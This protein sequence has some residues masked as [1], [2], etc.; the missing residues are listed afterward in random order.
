MPEGVSPVD[1]GFAVIQFHGSQNPLFMSHFISL[2]EAAD[3][4]ARY[5]QY[6]EQILAT[7]YKNQNILPICET[8]DR[9]EI[10]TI[11]GKSGCDSLRIYYGMDTAYKVHAVIVGADTNG[12]DILPAGT[13]LTTTE[14][15]YIAERGFRCPDQ[16]PPDSDLNS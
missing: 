9:S 15:D 7:A 12:A 1:Q 14:D 4:T 3:M 16:C 6:R 5:R 10:D 8:F 13:S 2:T 11:L